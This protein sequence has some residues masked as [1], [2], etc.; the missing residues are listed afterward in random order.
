[1]ALKLKPWHTVA[2][3]REDLRKGKTAVDEALI[4]NAY[5][6]L[7]ESVRKEKKRLFHIPAGEVLQ[8][9]STAPAGEVA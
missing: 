5:E 4:W 2:A 7:V 3:P 8:N 1:M 9:E 6:K